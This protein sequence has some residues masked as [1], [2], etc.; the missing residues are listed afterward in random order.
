VGFQIG[1]SSTD[2]VMLIMNERGADKLLADKFTL[3]GEASGRRSRRAHGDGADRR[4]DA[5]RHPV[6][7]AHAGPVCRSGARRALAPAVLHVVRVV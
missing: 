6:V 2:L 3:G 7:V 5:R 1:G 4:A